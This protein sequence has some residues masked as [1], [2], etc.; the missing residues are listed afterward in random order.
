MSIVGWH[1]HL[2]GQSTWVFLSFSSVLLCQWSLP[3][4]FSFCQPNLGYFIPTLL[5]L[6]YFTVN[7]SSQFWATFR[8]FSLPLKPKSCFHLSRCFTKVNLES[9]ILLIAQ[10]CAFITFVFRRHFSFSTF[11]SHFSFSLKSQTRHWSTTYST[12]V[13]M[14]FLYSHRD[15]CPQQKHKVLDLNICSPL[16]PLHLPVVHGWFCSPIQVEGFPSGLSDSPVRWILRYQLYADSKGSGIWVQ[17]LA[18]CVLSDKSHAHN[19]AVWELPAG[20]WAFDSIYL[21]G[22][23]HFLE[24]SSWP[25]Y[26]HKRFLALMVEG[27]LLCITAFWYIPDLSKQFRKDT[28]VSSALL[29]GLLSS[30]KQASAWS[31]HVCPLVFSLQN[32]FTCY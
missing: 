11:I 24:C 7:I 29:Q 4:S 16:S 28:R 32:S 27:F 25:W 5:F 30:T 17:M 6:H 13:H 12:Y 26:V 1:R 15:F 22:N 10:E 31:T 2:L 23:P 9:W 18:K 14:E 3:P 19:G 21:A 20:C 8:L